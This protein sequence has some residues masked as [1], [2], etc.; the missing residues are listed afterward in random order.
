MKLYKFRSLANE[1][2]I[3]R[4]KDIIEEGFYCCNFLS[5]ND[6][7]EGVFT[8]NEKNIKIDMSEKQNHKICSFSGVNALNSQL[9]WGHYA[10][11]GMGIVIEIDV[12]KEKCSKIK[13]VKYSNLADNLNSIE[14][15]LTRKSEEWKYEDEFRYLSKEQ[16]NKVKIGNIVKIYFGAPYKNLNNYNDI[17]NK[18]EKLKEYLKLK[19]KLEYFW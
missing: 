16:N 13:K 9:M 14:K 2:D 3:K 19:N 15:I 7:N 8:V 11:T 17:K 6:M 18:H 12:I 1:S 4:I 10:N 5:F